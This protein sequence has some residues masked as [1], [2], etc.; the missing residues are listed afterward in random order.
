MSLASFGFAFSRTITSENLQIDFIFKK[1]LTQD[2]HCLQTQGKRRPFK[3]H[4]FIQL[5]SIHRRESS[6]DIFHVYSLF[7]GIWKQWLDYKQKENFTGGA[8]AGIWMFW[9]LKSNLMK[10]SPQD[11]YFR[12]RMAW[13]WQLSTTQ[14]LTLCSPT[15]A[16]GSQKERAKARKKTT[17]NAKASSHN[18]TSRLK[19]TQ[20]WCNDYLLQIPFHSIL[21]AE[22]DVMCMEYLVDKFGSAVQVLFTSNFPLTSGLLARGDRVGKRN[23]ALIQWKYCTV[24]KTLVCYQCCFSH[25]S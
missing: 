18:Y 13:P 4:S 17:S 21:S 14:S 3:K 10:D 11:C 24:A 25:K 2:I 12:V 1:S 9:E 6:K 7:I 20:F 22:H 15:V 19:P 23:K 8:L 16:W 5:F